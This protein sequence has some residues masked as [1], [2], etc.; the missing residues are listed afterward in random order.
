[1]YK[2]IVRRFLMMIPVL[3]GVIFIVF[4]IMSLTPTDAAEVILGNEGTPQE[5]ER[6][7]DEM[8]LNRPLLVQYGSYV[9]NLLQGDMGVSYKNNMCVSA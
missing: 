7:R 6:L 4:F 5:I 3:L 9:V 2:Y 1:M 8:G